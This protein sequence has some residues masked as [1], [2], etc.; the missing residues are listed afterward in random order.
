MAGGV[1]TD[2]PPVEEA[3]QAHDD[4]VSA[5]ECRNLRSVELFGDG[6]GLRSVH[7][8]TGTVAGYVSCPILLI[9]HEIA[10]GTL[11]ICKI[12]PKARAPGGLSGSTTDTH[13]L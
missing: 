11:E 3:T 1:S 6:C 5:A 9:F 8:V 12:P 2:W 7:R 4:E 10:I 13:L